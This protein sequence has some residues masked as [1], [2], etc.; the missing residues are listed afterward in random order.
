MGLSLLSLSA[1]ACS[2][3]HTTHTL[4]LWVTTIR[5]AVINDVCGI[6]QKSARLMTW[7]LYFLSPSVCL[8]EWIM[9]QVSNMLGSYQCLTE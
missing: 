7:L 1:R 2:T 8:L 6:V 3:M 4:R 9:N 5:L